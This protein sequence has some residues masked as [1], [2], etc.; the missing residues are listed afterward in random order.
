MS[1][2]GLGRGLQSLLPQ[3][4]E[5]EVVNLLLSSV[6][7]DPEQPRKVVG[8][9]ELKE[10][11]DSIREHGVLQPVLVRPHPEKTG[12]Y[13]VIAGE[14]RYRAS[15]LAGKESI[16]AV[17]HEVDNR[18]A[19][20][21][22]LIENLQRQDLNPIEEALA[23]KRLMEEFSLTQEGVAE[24]VGK[25]RSHVANMIRLLKLAEK[26]KEALINGTITM[27]HAKVLLSLPKEGQEFWC[28]RVV[29][30]G[31]TV[32]ELERLLALEKA[33][34]AGKK[35]PKPPS[36]LKDLEKRL[37]NR[38]KGVR[39]TVGKKGYKMIMPFSSVEEIEEF[40]KRLEPEEE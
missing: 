3:G 16:P 9:D 12:A 19:L 15:K 7:L 10:L 31:L 30:K 36:A 14:R 8:E 26:V 35:R 5:H 33:R 13:L 38:Y 11:A 29:E 34:E 21:I 24:E 27:G 1:K 6:E 39:F 23:Y 18:T 25:S 17:V 28:Q 22:A 20:A 4:G 32:R 37:R 2:R 40:C